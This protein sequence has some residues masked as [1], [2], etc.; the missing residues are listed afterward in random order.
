MLYVTSEYGYFETVQAYF[1]ELTGKG[2]VLSSR[3]IEALSA[4]Q[5][6]G[7][8]AA[9]I[10]KGIERAVAAKASKPRDIWACRAWIEPLVEISRARAVESPA[11]EDSSSSEV[12]TSIEEAGRAADREAFKQ[13]YREAWLRLRSQEV[14]R[15]WET[16]V[17]VDAALV[18]AF[19]AALNE[20]EQKALH[21]TILADPSLVGMT[22]EARERHVAAR[23]RRLLKERFGLVSPLDV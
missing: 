13:A 22:A 9:T 21:R 11:S 18:S 12:L 4:W 19:L 6:Q 15:S 20:D 23:T 2:L 8:T 3:D 5:A 1:L 7:A 16:L 14:G 17:E 10:C